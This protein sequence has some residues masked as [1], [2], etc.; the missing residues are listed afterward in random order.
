MCSRGL[1]RGLQI[2]HHC[3][4]RFANIPQAVGTVVPS[5]ENDV[6]HWDG[7]P[8]FYTFPKCTLKEQGL[9]YKECLTLVVCCHERFIVSQLL[10]ARL[11]SDSPERQKETQFKTLLLLLLLPLPE[12]NTL[13]SKNSCNKSMEY[14][15]FLWFI[16]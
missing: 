9:S 2:V 1:L 13:F 10:T 6:F 8:D 5:S 15:E 14:F 12:D 4:Y 16:I 3:F 11:T 7:K